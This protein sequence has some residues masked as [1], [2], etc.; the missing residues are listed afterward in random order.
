MDL[1]RWIAGD[2]RRVCAQV[3]TFQRDIQAEDTCQALLQFTGGGFGVLECTTSVTP[4]QPDRLEFHG[5]RGTIRLERDRIVQW[6]VD[7]FPRPEAADPAGEADR[8]ERPG[9]HLPQLRD[10]VDAIREGRPPAVTAEDGLAALAIVEA[11]YRSARA[12]RW[13]DVEPVGSQTDA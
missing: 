13:V 11:I 9:S 2:V 4:A 1:L 5:S 8:P 6:E 12:G 3:A 10:I 7:G